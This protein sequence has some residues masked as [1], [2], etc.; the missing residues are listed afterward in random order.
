ME[1]KNQSDR[2]ITSATS[3][4]LILQQQPALDAVR[5]ISVFLVFLF[6]AGVSG[7]SGAFIGVDI[8]FVLSGFL[9]TLLLLQEYQ[10]KGSIGIRKF[11]MRRVLRL[12]PGLVMMLLVFIALVYLRF[13]D[14]AVR[15]R[16]TRDALLALLYVANWVRAFDINPLNMLGHTWS[17]A[18]EEQFYLLWPLLMRLLLPLSGLVRSI[19]IASLFF[20]SWGWR[21]VLLSGGASWN[22][23]YN[24]LDCR[25]DMLLAGCLLASLWNAGYLDFWGRSRLLS[26]ISVAGAT[27]GLAI[28]STS[29]DWQKPPLYIWQ[30]ALVALTASIVI[31]EVI[32]APGGLFSRFLNRRWLVWPGKV[33]YGIYLWHYPV[34]LLLA[35]TCLDAPLQAP[36]AAMLTLLFAALSWYG[37]ERPFLRLKARFR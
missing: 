2:L 23:L 13:D 22:R 34:I 28:M 11:Y 8:F 21:L 33:S 9:I 6:H 15:Q 37:V 3:A 7:F 16:Q 35:G 24:G 12:M 10:A 17:L 25:V 14:Q 20:L 18:S 19:I 4:L 26:L 32:A 5:G 27:I 30:Y 36:A 1:I 29:V 31:L